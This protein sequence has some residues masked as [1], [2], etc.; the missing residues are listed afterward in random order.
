M[1]AKARR[2][3]DCNGERD[4]HMYCPRCG[5][6][7][8]ANAPAC[9]SCGGLLPVVVAGVVPVQVKTSGLAIAAFV[10]GILSLFTLGVTALPAIVLGVIALI[11]IGQSGGRLAGTGLAVVGMVLPVFSFVVV[12][13]AVMMPALAR[14]RQLAFRM[15]CGTNLSGL[16]KAMLIYADDY[17][18]ELP[19]AGGRST[20]WAATTPDWLGVDRRQA[21]DLAADDSGGQASISSSLY[22][23]VKYAQVT[24]KSFVCK[25]DVGTTEFVPFPDMSLPR[26]FELR[27]AWDFGPPEDS[28]K[29]CSYAYHMPY[30][31]F[32]LTTSNEPGFAVAADRNPWIDSP[33]GVRADFSRFK[34]DVH[35]FA[36][37]TNQARNGNAMTHQLD[38]QNVLFLDGHVEFAKR[39]FCGVENDNIYTISSSPTAGDPLGTPPTLGSQPAN[40]KDSLL[41][42]DPISPTKGR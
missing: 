34:P 1:S 9:V 19:R 24:P 21:F 41:V 36:G 22:L 26:D 17:N 6:Q 16:G 31:Q 10:L 8:A 5:T 2:P 25:G 12:L 33:S 37:T 27:D 38:G 11:V 4:K 14:T 40:R 30:G 28:S 39:A 15:T 18:G 7:N 3:A 20:Q 32:A 42:N 29:H 35:P 23:L 13:G